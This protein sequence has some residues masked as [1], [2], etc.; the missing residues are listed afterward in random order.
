MLAGVQCSYR[1]C[2]AGRWV[3]VASWESALVSGAAITVQQPQLTTLIPHEAPLNSHSA[4]R[5][6]AFTHTQRGEHGGGLSQD[7]GQRFYF[8]DVMR[9][10][11]N[12][13][14]SLYPW[15]LWNGILKYFGCRKALTNA[16]LYSSVK[17]PPKHV[18]QLLNK[19][20]FICLLSSFIGKLT[21]YLYKIIFQIYLKFFFI[22]FFK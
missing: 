9:V 21:A 20:K 12:E 11:I 7:N 1:R 17:L 16:K 3:L 22:L 6:A 8:S 13:E 18:N 19:P 14:N 2:V 15:K 4:G 5:G 10:K